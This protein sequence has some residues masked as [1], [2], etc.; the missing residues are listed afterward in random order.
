MDR[1]DFLKTGGAVAASVAAGSAA[2]QPGSQLRAPAVQSGSIRLLLAAGCEPDAPGSA[3]GRLARRIEMVS[4]GR[5][6]VELWGGSAA[7][8]DLIFG[9]AHEHARHHPAFAFFAGLPRGH[10][11]DA[12]SLAAWLAVGGGQ[13]LW[14]ELAAGFGFKPLLAGHTGPGAGLWSNRRLDA[15]SDFAGTKLFAVGLAC[16]V[17]RALGADAVELA[18][19][20]LAAA[21]AEGRV[22][23]AEWPGALAALTLQPPADRLYTPGLAPAGTALA[24]TVRRDLWERMG[25]TEQAILEACAT[26]EYHAGLAEAQARAMV[27]AQVTASVQRLPLASEIAAALDRA[28]ADAVGR[29]AT[30]DPH[31]Q[32]I[33][34]SY[35]AFR[36]LTASAGPAAT[37]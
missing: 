26:A 15:A 7:E 14:D 24:L 33:A 32:R 22:E 17:A 25:A 12:A 36:A 16:D 2:A 27:E 34:D 37:A 3:A 30:A 35:R 9:S 18:P 13:M 6:S 10:G 5:F 4:G 8:A 21:L 19:Q 28:A 11:L 1:R 29:L 20:E 31:A 23:A